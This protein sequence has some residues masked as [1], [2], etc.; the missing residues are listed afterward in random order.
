MLVRPERHADDAA[1]RGEP[2]SRGPIVDERCTGGGTPDVSDGLAARAEHQG[3]AVHRYERRGRL[4]LVC[5]ADAHEIEKAIIVHGRQSSRA[6][7]PTPAPIGGTTPRRPE[8]H[9]FGGLAGV[10]YPFNR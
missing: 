5:L 9:L 4:G 1:A 8:V 3:A 10:A 2:S 6:P 7:H